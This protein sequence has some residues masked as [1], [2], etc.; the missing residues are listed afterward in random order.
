MTSTRLVLGHGSRNSPKAVLFK[1]CFLD[2]FEEGT[3]KRKLEGWTTTSPT[4]PQFNQRRWGHL[5][6]N[7][8]LIGY[9]PCQG[10]PKDSPMVEY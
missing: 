4:L 6:G 1:T 2:A 10:D 5:G 3:E 7:R 8:L 9:F